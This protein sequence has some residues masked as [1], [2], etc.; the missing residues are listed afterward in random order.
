MRSPFDFKWRFA[1]YLKFSVADLWSTVMGRKKNETDETDQ[2]VLQIIWD[3]PIFY[4]R[5]MSQVNGWNV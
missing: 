1:K 5:L 3:I 2:V 4:F